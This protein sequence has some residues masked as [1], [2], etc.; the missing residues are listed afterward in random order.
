MW[1]IAHCIRK[2]LVATQAEA[3]PHLELAL[4]PP[5]P[6]ASRAFWSIVDGKFS[7]FPLTHAATFNAFE[8]ELRIRHTPKKKKQQKTSH[9]T[10][11]RAF[12]EMVMRWGEK[13]EISPLSFSC[14]LTACG[15]Y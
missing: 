11:D 7:L 5:F 10:S 15:F 14:V 12:S 13:S 4:L 1:D 9:K 8:D 2:C 3:V 6:F